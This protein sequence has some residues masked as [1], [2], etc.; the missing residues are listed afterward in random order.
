M[1]AGDRASFTLFEYGKNREGYWKCTNLVGFYR[2][3]VPLAREL[4]PGARLVFVFDNSMN[5][6][7][8]REDGLNAAAFNLGK[9][10]KVSVS[11]RDGWF[12]KDGVRVAQRMMTIGGLLRSAKD[13][14]DE[15]GIQTRG[16]KK[17][18]GIAL[19]AS[20][21][22]FKAQEEWLVEVSRE[23]DCD[24]VFLP[25]FHC[26]LNPIE[27]FWG[28]L[29]R[30]LRE[31]CD[32][33]YASLRGRIPV[34]LKTFPRD[35]SHRIFRRMVRWLSVYAGVGDQRLSPAQAAFVVK[36]YSSHR[37]VPEADLSAVLGGDGAE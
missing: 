11:V 14:L 22:D 33:E 13:I 10:K 6:H 37:R 30:R 7:M 26:E 31:E 21:P 12:E 36:K 24:I 2:Q 29:K 4:H 28:W 16:L 23:L 27:M 35:T 20:Q 9:A 1:H 17:Q 25:K 3:V 32:F 19:L 15:R 8:T 18:A 34:L 5:H